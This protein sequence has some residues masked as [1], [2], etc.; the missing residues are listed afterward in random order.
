MKKTRSSRI[1]PPEQI[2]RPGAKAFGDNRDWLRVFAAPL[3]VFCCT[4]HFA[5]GKIPALLAR[6]EVTHS[7]LSS[8]I[9]DAVGLVLPAW[10]ESP[11]LVWAN[12]EFNVSTGT[13]ATHPMLFGCAGKAEGIRQ[14][15]LVVSSSWV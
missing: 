11:G 12:P 8:R 7:C 14:I 6:L 4:L 15:F 2:L 9:S 1:E 3:L 10:A 13:L 5:R